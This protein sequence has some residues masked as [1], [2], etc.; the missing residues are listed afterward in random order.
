MT[1]K[2]HEALRAW[3]NQM[4]PEDRDRALV[5]GWRMIYGLAA[6]QSRDED[7]LDTVAALWEKTAAELEQ[8]NAPA[9]VIAKAKRMAK[10]HR[11]NS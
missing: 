11:S 1:D 5:A 10:M 9:D 8:A 3:C 2:E 7:N 4:T 6:K